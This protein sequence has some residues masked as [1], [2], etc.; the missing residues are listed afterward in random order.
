MENST[1][2]L[3]P[4]VKSQRIQIFELNLIPNFE[5]FTTNKLNVI[6]AP[7]SVRSMHQKNQSNVFSSS[8]SLVFGQT[9]TSGHGP[10]KSGFAHVHLGT[11]ILL[12]KD[13]RLLLPF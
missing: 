8:Y 7:P 9:S 6:S 12:G 11:T 13:L 5:K 1:L 10:V 2:K 3:I 4:N